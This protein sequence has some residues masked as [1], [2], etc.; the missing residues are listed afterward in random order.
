MKEHRSLPR[1]GQWASGLTLIAVGV[2][3]G[4]TSLVLNTLHGY[5][6]GLATA[7][8]FAL[9]DVG[10][11]AL[12]IVCV[13]IGWTLQTRLT[14]A[15]C[16]VVSVTCAASYYLD[17]SGRQL[18]GQEHGAAVAADRAK[19][20]AELEQELATA[21]ALAADEAKKR[22]CGEKCQA[23]RADAVKASQRL[24]DAR[25]ARAATPVAAPSGLVVLA[26]SVAS[27]DEFSAGRWVMGLKA[28]LAIILLETLVYLSIPGGQMIG[29][30]MRPAT[31]GT[32]SEQPADTID[33][34][35][36]PKPTRPRDA[37]GRY[38]K[39]EPFKLHAVR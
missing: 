14:L 1:W 8:L 30:A 6:S 22:G 3:A 12:P 18:F 15:V 20:I 17:N 26:A 39:K 29:V 5:E 16:A 34:D 7:I 9:A 10:K 11:T 25:E 35:S 2:S 32:D 33:I 31:V 4:A 21:N 23:F 38:I 13:A 36:M 28:L 19:S 27:T 24:Q 37:R